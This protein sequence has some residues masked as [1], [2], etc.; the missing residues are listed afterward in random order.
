MFRKKGNF[1]RPATL[2]KKTFWHKCFPVNIA[3]FLRTSIFTEHLRWLLLFQIPSNFFVQYFR[4]F[5]S[6]PDFAA[7]LIEKKNW[8][9]HHI[10][11]S[12]IHIFTGAF[13]QSFFKTKIFI[14]WIIWRDRFKRSHYQLIYKIIIPIYQFVSYPVLD[15]P[16]ISIFLVKTP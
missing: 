14:R 9:L 1:A 15:P 11:D 3:K 5:S 13:F 6:K 8:H 12:R 7:G 2:L 10:T 4:N 16:M